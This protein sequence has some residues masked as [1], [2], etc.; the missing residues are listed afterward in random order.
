MFHRKLYPGFEGLSFAFTQNYNTVVLVYYE[1]RSDKAKLTEMTDGT[2]MK[3]KIALKNEGR[4]VAVYVDVPFGVHHVELK[5]KLRN[6]LNVS[7]YLFGDD[8]LRDQNH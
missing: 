3:W 8:E 7:L 4:K 5:V 2:E 6:S 1:G